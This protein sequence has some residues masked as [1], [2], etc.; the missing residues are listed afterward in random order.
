MPLLDVSLVDLVQ[1]GFRAS[2][3]PPDGLLHCS[4]DLCG[5]LRHAQL[6]AAG[7]PMIDEDVVSETR[8]M[9]GTLMHG[10]VERYLRSQPVMLEVKLDRWL[11]EGW[12]GTADHF[13]W[14]AEK[15]GFVLTDLKT[16]KPEGMPYIIKGGIKDE[17]MHQL[18]A[19]WWAAVRAGLPMVHG[20]GVLYLPV[21]QIAPKDIAR[22]GKVAPSFQEGTPYPQEYIEGLMQDRWAATKA[23]L[24]EVQLARILDPDFWITDSLAP[25]QDRVP[26]LSLN[27]QLKVPKLSQLLVPHWSATYCPFPDELCDCSTQKVQTV[28]SWDLDP[29]GAPVY[30][31]RQGVPQPDVLT[32]PTDNDIAALVKA[33]AEK[34]AA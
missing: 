15:R 28:G 2:R 29:D 1:D 9:L 18:S 7:A 16:I 26:K 12:S 4:G 33:R 25:V 21:G 19:Y 8:L 27:K 22:V 13:V 23:Y 31:P 3:R 20:I 24:Q 17:H 30:I 6:K 14:N 11:P 5:S 10:A 32:T 34:E